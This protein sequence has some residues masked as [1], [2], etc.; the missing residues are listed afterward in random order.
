MSDVTERAV[1]RSKEKGLKGVETRCV[2]ERYDE[3]ASKT[4]S[5]FGVV[6]GVCGISIRGVTL[7]MRQVSSSTCRKYVTE[8][9]LQRLKFSECYLL[10]DSK[11]KRRNKSI[12]KENK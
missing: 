3:E 4:G 11:K 2:R 8:E 10:S 1:Q 12:K 6:Q 9:I 7:R 5:L